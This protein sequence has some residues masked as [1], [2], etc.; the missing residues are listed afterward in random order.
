ML[1]M[2]TTLAVLVI[3]ALV[4]LAVARGEHLRPT[5]DDR[6]EVSLPTGRP[7]R[8]TDLDEVRFTTALRG[9]R[10]SEVDALVARL[11]AELAEREAGPRPV[12]PDD[13]TAPVVEDERRGR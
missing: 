10:M 2:L 3:G 1:W 6:R 11:A 13:P 12:D 7:L 4:V 8:S 9:Y 5:D